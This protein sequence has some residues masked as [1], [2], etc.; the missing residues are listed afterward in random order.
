MCIR[1]RYMGYG[2]EQAGAQEIEMQNASRETY[3]QSG[4]G[5]AAQRR[6]TY[7]QAPQKVKR[8]QTDIGTDES[9]DLYAA[10]YGDTGY[11]PWPPILENVRRA[12]EQRDRQR[13]GNDYQRYGNRYEGQYYTAATDTVES[14]AYQ[15][16]V[17]AIDKGA[18]LNLPG[19][20]IMR[21]IQAS[22]SLLPNTNGQD[23]NLLAYWGLSE[24]VY[25]WQG[26]GSTSNLVWEFFGSDAYLA[27]NDNLGYLELY[28]FDGQDFTN[29]ET[30][31]GEVTLDI[32]QVLSGNSYK[33]TLLNNGQVVGEISF[34]IVQG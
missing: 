31:L 15:Q 22:F 32:Q 25:K 12:L 27:N 26:Q 6:G 2:Y 23:I 8:D 17:E 33:E 24:G 20:I 21:K 19:A 30:K 28:I 11:N 5:V 1:D 9:S 13:Y 14:G 29:Q 34:D 7:S 16:E 18:N 4:A 3:L 10:K